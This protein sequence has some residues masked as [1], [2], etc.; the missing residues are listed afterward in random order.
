MP[1]IQ[2]FFAAALFVVGSLLRKPPPEPEAA[3]FEDFGFPDVNPTK[4]IPIIWGKKRVAS[5][6]TM[7]VVGYRTRRIRR[8]NFITGRTTIGH[9]YYAGIQMGICRGSADGVV[10]KKIILDNKTVWEGTSTVSDDGY[11]I[12]VR[13]DEFFGEDDGIRGTIRFF[14]GTPTQ[15][16]SSYLSAQH[17]AAGIT[18]TPAY[19]HVCYAVFEDF[20][21]GNAPTVRQIEFVCER[22]PDTLGIGN[23]R[24]INTSANTSPS[25]GAVDLA[26][27][28]IVHEILTDNNWG[29]GENPL[30]EIGSSF[31]SSAST[32]RG[33]GNAMSMIWNDGDSIEALLNTIMQQAN[34]FVFKRMSTGE[35]DMNLARDD[36]LDSPLDGSP[37]DSANLLEFDE[38]N[39]KLNKYSRGSW[40]ETFNVFNV[41]WSD[42]NLKGKP[43][44]AHAQDMANFAITNVR[45][46]ATYNFPGC[47]SV[48]LANDLAS[49][50]MRQAS[51][52]LIAAE[53]ETGRVAFDLVPGDVVIYSNQKLGVSRVFMR[54]TRID[55]GTPQDGRIRM[56]LLQ[57]IFGASATVFGAG[58]PTLA[59]PQTSDPQPPSP[60]FVFDMPHFM[61]KL[62]ADYQTSPYTEKPVVLARQPIGNAL[63]FR[64]QSKL[65]SESEYT[66]EEF[67]FE[68]TAAGELSRDLIEN[69]EAISP[70]GDDEDT[71]KRLVIE[72]VDFVGDIDE[73]PRNS[74]SE[75]KELGKGLILIESTGSPRQEYELL[76]YEQAAVD[77]STVTLTD[78]H[79]GLMDT[80]PQI[81]KQGDRVWFLF[82][83]IGTTDRNWGDNDDLDIRVQTVSSLGTTAEGSNIDLQLRDRM[84]KPIV[85][86]GVRF[87]SSNTGPQ[88]FP[89]FV[90][91]G[92]I[93]INVNRRPI[94]RQAMDYQQDNE[95][96]NPPPSPLDTIEVDVY[97]VV[98][99]V[100][101]FLRTISTT[102]NI[103]QYQKAEQITDGIYGR[104]FFI[105]RSR[106]QDASP[107]T[108]SLVVVKRSML[109]NSA[110]FSPIPSP[111]P[112]VVNSPFP[113]PA[114]PTPSPLSPITS[115]L[116]PRP[117]PISPVQSPLSPVPSPVSPA[118]SPKPSPTVSPK[119]SPHSPVASPLS[120][121]PSPFSPVQSPI[122][123]LPS[124]LGA[125]NAFEATLQAQGVDHFWRLD[126]VE[127]RSP[128]TYEDY[129]ASFD[130]DL[131]WGP[132][133]R[134]VSNVPGAIRGV[135]NRHAGT[136]MQS[137]SLAM[138]INPDTGSP[139]PG[140]VRGSVGTV[141]FWIR[142]PTFNALSRT[143][144]ITVYYYEFSNNGA[145]AHVVQI[146]TGGA[147]RMVVDSNTN[148]YIAVTG[149][150][151]IN[152]EQWHFVVVS[153]PGDGNGV[154]IYVDGALVSPI[155]HTT[156][157]TGTLD[158]WLADLEAAFGPASDYE[159]LTSAFSGNGGDQSS[160][161]AQIQYPFQH[162]AALDASDVEDLWLGRGSGVT[163]YYHA[164]QDIADPLYWQAMSLPNT[165]TEG[166]ALG[167][168]DYH[169][170]PSSIVRYFDADPMVTSYSKDAISFENSSAQMF[171]SSQNEDIFNISPNVGTIFLRFAPGRYTNSGSQ[172]S[173]IWSIG[174]STTRYMRITYED[175]ILKFEILTTSGSWKVAVD[176]VPLQGGSPR[177]SPLVW[178]NVAVV[179]YADVGTVVYI[180]GEAYTGDDVTI[181]TT[182]S[183]I[184]ETSW[185]AELFADGSVTSMQLSGRLGSGSVDRA[186]D[187]LLSQAWISEQALTWTQVYNIHRATLGEYDAKRSPRS[188]PA[189][190]L[191]SPLS[192]RPSPV[193]PVPSP[194]SPIAS[195]QPPATFAAQM[196]RFDNVVEYYMDSNGLSPAVLK[197]RGSGGAAYDMVPFESPDPFLG[198]GVGAAYRV[199]GGDFSESPS[200]AIRT[201]AYSNDAGLY[202]IMPS[203]QGRSPSQV[204]PIQLRPSPH[205][206]AAVYRGHV[207]IVFRTSTTPNTERALWSHHNSDSGYEFYIGMTTGGALVWDIRRDSSAF[208]QRVIT[209]GQN[210]ADGRWHMLTVVQPGGAYN[211]SPAEGLL[212]YMDGKRVDVSDNVD[213]NQERVW[214]HSF[215]GGSTQEPLENMGFGGRLNGGAP[216]TTLSSEWNGDIAYFSIGSV[217]P[218]ES[219][220]FNAFSLFSGD[221]PSPFASPYLLDSPVPSPISPYPSPFS[222]IP[223][224]VNSPLEQSFL[225]IQELSQP[226]LTWQLDQASGNLVA[227]GAKATGSKFDLQPLSPLP[228][229]LPYQ[230][231]GGDMSESP[232]YGIRMPGSP[233]NG[234]AFVTDPGNSLS[235]ESP[236]PFI[237]VTEGTVTVAFKL[238]ADMNNNS[239]AYLFSFLGDTNYRIHLE[240]ETTGFVQFYLFRLASSLEKRLRT[241]TSVDLRD[242]QWHV[243]HF[244]Y[245][246]LGDELYPSPPA[247]RCY[248]DGVLQPEPSNS[249]SGDATGYW[250]D[251]MATNYEQYGIGARALSTPGTTWAS[252][253]AV[254]GQIA[255]VSVGSE[256]MRETWMK[257]AADAF[258]RNR[259]SPNE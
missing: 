135:P 120:P 31:T 102:S 224:P 254:K 42:R 30:T 97:G 29:L 217:V 36:Y 241:D 188:S 212:V 28:E 160:F 235:S 179:H 247:G 252:G 158:Y 209:Q 61:A 73:S 82:G 105:V 22:Y 98:G 198:A 21:W 245:D 145:L 119:P 240:V 41:N 256:I 238:D 8:G 161:S 211:G 113:S 70:R 200:Y 46:V 3:A 45:N 83:A 178:Y 191:P 109:Y 81:A 57:D 63:E 128:K 32:L 74:D 166:A 195:P 66:E 60:S 190:P 80:V 222:P 184:D 213:A 127:D 64:V 48:E 52:P 176:A 123:P 136:R 180:D 103:V 147:V 43:N 201:G 196:A 112:F 244:V 223:S 118:G 72:N 199:D 234:F 111:A 92:I 225:E 154:R 163:D 246:E 27:P 202:A 150:G 55:F 203:P 210:Y 131:R 88:R 187:T 194:L 144:P 106:L 101:N 44:P 38:D 236:R 174:N 170:R 146:T 96:E 204:S 117:S 208:E 186:F 99:G 37:A 149:D 141:G 230:A 183:G 116:S 6:H 1:L 162:S 220:L 124:P 164:V 182:G 218:A 125:V 107:G 4:R 134:F 168:T 228:S 84:S 49:R 93:Q 242:G 95:T 13:D 5:I 18:T 151:V 130:A 71:I 15:N 257:E 153:Q 17:S 25:E 129:G 100:R 10:L 232:S 54:V 75:I 192:P 59:I 155:T 34:G 251:I 165:S 248:L 62:V 115:P 156:N 79:R 108:A 239:V 167:K 104:Y 215:P 91:P 181:T 206:L 221:R 249:D 14:P 205:P 26:I 23:N 50:V 53:I 226:I 132:S 121:L 189:S 219:E 138:N 233:A 157:G 197:N 259:P 255:Y 51:W 20:Y 177:P 24:K 78:V 56:S 229:P 90:D 69:A 172:E 214:F 137:G 216:P 227:T 126:E 133:G 143:A 86:G 89:G 171:P 76:G 122:S 114:S 2:I 175:L 58:Q 243:V 185:F 193:S 39:S 231:Y 12:N 11:E 94:E 207:T 40:E 67:G 77:G 19:R 159:W 139:Y 173:T 33:E 47:H 253:D 87:G 7:D 142:I 110:D 169:L 65:N 9:R 85:P 68:W 237:D 152:D 16:V 250:F 35:W 140:P 258:H 148:E